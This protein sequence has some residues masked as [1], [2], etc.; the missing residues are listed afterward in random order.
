MHAGNR[1]RRAL[2]LAALVFAAACEHEVPLV[3][4]PAGPAA[5]T[6]PAATAPASASPDAFEAG[7]WVE[8]AGAEPRRRL[9]PA[10]AADARQAL[11]LRVETQAGAG[12]AGGP[13]A[14]MQTP[15]AE[16]DFTVTAPG[17]G[18]GG[19]ALDAARSPAVTAQPDAPAP[20]PSLVALFESTLAPLTGARGPYALTAGT[21]Q[22]WRFDA[23]AGTAPPTAEVLASLNDALRNFDLRMPEVDVGAGARWV[24]RV[25]VGDGPLRLHVTRRVTLTRF[26]AEGAELLVALEIGSAQSGARVPAVGGA[27]GGVTGRGAGTLVVDPTRALPV[28]G[29][30]EIETRTTHVG[31]GREDVP[32]LWALETRVRATLVP[33]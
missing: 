11:R 20:A 15:A 1:R 24:E 31:G 7:L 17:A 14:R 2:P 30:L 21:P 10:P 33:R 12:T 4:P 26:G 16:V 22:A 19:L 29:A 23:P 28:R 18:P 9:T 25:S 13:T 3:S 27:S 32:G 5:P 8:D 6:T